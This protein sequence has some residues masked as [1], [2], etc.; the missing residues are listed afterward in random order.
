MGF[1]TY[2]IAFQVLPI[3]GTYLILV[4]FPLIDTLSSNVE[5]N[6]LQIQV[7]QGGKKSIK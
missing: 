2:N 4:D 3:L 5:N 1:Y 7:I 6:E